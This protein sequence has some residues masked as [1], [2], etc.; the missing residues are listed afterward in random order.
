VWLLD[1]DLPE[2]KTCSTVIAD[3]LPA[4]FARRDTSL[5]RPPFQLVTVKDGGLQRGVDVRTLTS[6]SRPT[7]AEQDRGKQIA[8][9]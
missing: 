3:A 8:R 7:I 2:D 6:F 5:R 9:V 4:Q 1:V